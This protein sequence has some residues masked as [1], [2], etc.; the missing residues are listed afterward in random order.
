M[1][2]SDGQGKYGSIRRDPG[3]EPAHRLPFLISDLSPIGFVFI[4]ELDTPSPVNSRSMN[5]KI[6]QYLRLSDESMIRLDMDR[7]V[8]S[9]RHGLTEPISWKRPVRDVIAEVLALIQAD[10]VEPDL[11][12]WDLYVEAARLR[13]IDVDADTLRILPQNVMFSDQ[14]AEIYEF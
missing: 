9:F 2:F 4:C 14:L 3:T 6:T 8:S 11:F 12:P 1:R 13:G 7:G 10:A 5:M